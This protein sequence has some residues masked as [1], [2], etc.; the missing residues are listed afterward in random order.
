M[1]ATLGPALASSTK[2]ILK[3]LVIIFAFFFQMSKTCYTKEEKLTHKF[4][5]R[6]RVANKIQTHTVVIQVGM[7]LTIKQQ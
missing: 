4:I 2:K 7:C 1:S 5:I 6:T 3:L